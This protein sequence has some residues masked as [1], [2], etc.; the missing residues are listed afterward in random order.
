MMAE[1]DWRMANISK[2]TYA[3]NLESLTSAADNPR[4]R[5]SRT[6]KCSDYGAGLCLTGY[7]HS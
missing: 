3:G 1:T 2:L 6:D 7:R 5:F 4:Y